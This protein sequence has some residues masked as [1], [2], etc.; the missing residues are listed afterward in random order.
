MK[1]GILA[2]SVL[3]LYSCSLK[4]HPELKQFAIDENIR[5]QRTI[6]KEIKVKVES[7][8]CPEVFKDLF[9]YRVKDG[10]I[11]NTFSSASWVSSECSMFENALKKALLKSGFDVVEYGNYRYKLLFSLDKFNENQNNKTASVC[12]DFWLKDAKTKDT[13]L[14]FNVCKSKKLENT[15][16]NTV[17][18]KLNKLTHLVIKDALEKLISYF[19]KQKGS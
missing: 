6:T 10:V 17:V 3:L 12:S 15:S 16:V 7:V 1:K 13:L 18:K 4:P 2:F 19:K 5:Q 9:I 14:T 8:S 11:Y